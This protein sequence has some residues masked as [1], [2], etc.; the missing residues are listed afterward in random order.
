M[1]MTLMTL[2]HFCAY[3][4]AH[5]WRWFKIAPNIRPN[6]IVSFTKPT[7][8][9]G[10]MK[11]RLQSKCAW[12]D[13]S[14]VMKYFSTFAS[15]ESVENS[16]IKIIR[17]LYVC[18]KPEA[19]EHLFRFLNLALKLKEEFRNKLMPPIAF[20]QVAKQAH[21]QSGECTSW[22]GPWT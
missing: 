21:P 19:G 20:L 22:L 8:T 1:I 10:G 12:K 11:N 9:K 2:Q 16:K 15:K 5:L 7:E 14:L 3:S 18:Q 6:L 13:S 4:N 17:C